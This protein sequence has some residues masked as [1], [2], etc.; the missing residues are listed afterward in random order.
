MR[1]SAMCRDAYT[2]VGA[3][4]VIASGL[5]VFIANGSADRGPQRAPDNNDFLRLKGA[6][7]A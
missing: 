2:L 7:R 6:V 3:S 4:I 5:Y 1:Y